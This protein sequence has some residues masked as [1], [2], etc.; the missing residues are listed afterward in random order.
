MTK[1]IYV[2]DDEKCIANTRVVILSNSGHEAFLSTTVVYGVRAETRLLLP[3]WRHRVATQ[4][5]NTEAY[6][7][8]AKIT[9]CRSS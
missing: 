9:A 8:D 7:P 4:S 1:R 6:S 2:V 3:P 5:A